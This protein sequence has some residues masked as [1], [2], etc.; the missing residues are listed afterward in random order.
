L[1]EEPNQDIADGFGGTVPFGHVPA[2]ISIDLVRSYFDPD[3]PF[4]LPPSSCLDAS[5]RV[6]GYAREHDVPVIHTRVVLGPEAMD[7]GVFVK[8]IPALRMYI[9][10]NSMNEIMP[11]VAPRD[12]ELVIVKQYASAFF[13]TSLSSTLRALGV[14]T[15]IMI[16]VSTSGCIRASAVDA[17]QNGFVSVV[18]RDAVGDRGPEPH[19]ANLY[20]LQAKYS[21]VV[22]EKTVLRYFEALRG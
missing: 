20:D 2:V 13:G 21:E 14:D 15:V 18:V 12:D 19:N 6:I 8:K 17:L 10:E 1:S 3:S 4:F 22:D 7:S 9:G 11:E 16:G 5:A